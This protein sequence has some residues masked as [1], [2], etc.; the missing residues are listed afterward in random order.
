[1]VIGTSPSLPKS[2]PS[3]LSTRSSSDTPDTQTEARLTASN[4]KI[5]H[6]RVTTTQRGLACGICQHWYHLKCDD[7]ISLNLYKCLVKYPAD[8]ILYLCPGCKSKCNKDTSGSYILPKLDLPISPKWA[9]HRSTKRHRPASCGHPSPTQSRSVGTQT[10]NSASNENLV[11]PSNQSKSKKKLATISQ[12]PQPPLRPEVTSNQES[13]LNLC[14]TDAAPPTS[15]S[16]ILNLLPIGSTLKPTYSSVAATEH[17]SSGKSPQK[18]NNTVGCITAP[19]NPPSNTNPKKQVR[20]E[21][22]RSNPPTEGIYRLSVVL[23]NVPEPTAT[24]LA[25]REAHDSEQWDCI[26]TKL[27]LPT[28]NPV[29]LQRLSR[30]NTPLAEIDNRPRLLKVS[31]QN[32]MHVERVLLSAATSPNLLHPIRIRADLTRSER[33]RR[34]QED[35]THNRNASQRRCVILRGIPEN[36]EGNTTLHEIQQWNYVRDRLNSSAVAIS[37]ARLPRPSHLMHL[38]APKLLR[39]TL[40]TETM[41]EELLESWHVLRSKLPA[42]IR[43]HRDRPRPERQQARAEYR[44]TEPTAMSINLNRIDYVGTPT[45]KA[46]SNPP[47][48]TTPLV[49]LASPTV[50]KNG[51]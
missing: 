27:G 49:S 16:N 24:D 12:K 47:L 21:P 13:I 4:C 9:D 6:A 31:F 15:T 26:C 17:S 5:C 37:I 51:E 44:N 7:A 3:S 39:I 46:T 20:T 25:K 36:T 8:G 34:A 48:S 43:L 28:S 23:F 18:N 29:Q 40:A 42:D 1:M 14:V 50:T 45:I 22:L 11:K 30:G 33:L 41:A 2:P 35:S 32:S 19:K 38:C 10:V